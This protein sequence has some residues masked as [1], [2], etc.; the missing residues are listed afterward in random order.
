MKNKK[1]FSLNS[2]T[3]DTIFSILCSHFVW[4]ILLHCFSIYFTIIPWYFV[5]KNIIREMSEFHRTLFC[6]LYCP[7]GLFVYRNTEVLVT[8]SCLTLWSHGLY[9]PWN[10]PSQN[11]GVCSLSL[12]QRIF[13]TQAS[14]PILPHCMWILYQ[15]SHK[16]SPDILIGYP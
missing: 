3:E 11:T 5:I 16:G 7:E 9:S 6:S 13:P 1:C 4:H 2:L 14:N 10:S 12:L 15:L 8:Q